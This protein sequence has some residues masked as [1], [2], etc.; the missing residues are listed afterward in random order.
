MRG[1]YSEGIGCWE[2]PCDTTP[3][4]RVERPPPTHVQIPLLHSAIPRRLEPIQTYYYLTPRVQVF[5]RDRKTNSIPHGQCPLACDRRFP[6]PPFHLVPQ[7]LHARSAGRPVQ[8]I[9]RRHITSR[10]DPST[11]LIYCDGSRMPDQDGLL[12]SGYGVAIFHQGQR[13]S[14]WSIGLGHHSTVFDAEMFA[15]AHAAS[16]IKRILDTLTPIRSVF[17]YSDSSSALQKIFDPSTHPGQMASLLFCA[18][19][20]A[21]L[22]K[23]PLLEITLQWCPGH[24]NVIGNEV[25]DSLAKAGISLPSLISCSYSSFKESSKTKVQRSWQEEWPSL[26]GTH[27]PIAHRTGFTNPPSIITSMTFNYT[28]RE[29]Y[30][31]VTQAMTGHG[32]FGDYYARFV[33]SESPWCPCSDEVL[34]PTWQDR[35]HIIYH[36]DRYSAHRDILQN[37]PLPILFNFKK[38]I[39]AFTQFLDKSGAFTKTG[40]PRPTPPVI[41]KKK[42]P[43]TNKHLSF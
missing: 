5:G 28:P 1:P 27:H 2:P 31:R 33:P 32:Y 35:D 7:P 42:K 21:L 12:S 18:S 43:P 30:G 36:C 16:K 6:S 23:F 14:A 15:L 26:G 4:Q 3:P 20:I 40:R 24:S 41:I 8:S 11:L 29:L 19:I 22:G 25:A 37:R 39:D 38:G 34:A 10:H 9:N 17:F 13:T